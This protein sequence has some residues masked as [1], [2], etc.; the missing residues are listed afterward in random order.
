MIKGLLDAHVHTKM[1]HHATGEMYEYVESAIALNLTTI[2]FSDHFPMFYLPKNID[3]SSYCMNMNELPIYINEV[4]ALQEKYTEIDIKIATE[5]DFITGK[6]TEIKESLN[7]FEFDYVLGSVHVI[8]NWCI[9]DPKNL[10]KYNEIDI[11]DIYRDYY[12]ILKKAVDSRLF[13]IMAHLDLVKKFGFR[14]D[15]DMS[16]SIDPVIDSLKKN[17]ICIELN[18]A[19]DRK[20]VKEFYPDRSILEKCYENDI[21]IS[22]GSD[23][24]KPEEVAWKFDDALELIR[25]IGYTQL[26]KFSNRKK[27][28]VDI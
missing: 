21:P 17:K 2:G 3:T 19:G 12:S 20:P 18:T 9:D 22:L 24:H 15:E 16:S 27:Q 26:V 11:S 1:C 28:F 6:K 8:S 4:K 7:K 14:P 25:D 10:Q 13:D 23:A 5:A